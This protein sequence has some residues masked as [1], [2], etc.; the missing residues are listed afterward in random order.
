H[1]RLP[2]R[3]RYDSRLAVATSDLDTALLVSPK[4]LAGAC[5]ECL[6]SQH[7]CLGGV[8]GTGAVSLLQDPVEPAAQLLGLRP[9]QILRQIPLPAG[10][11]QKRNSLVVVAAP[12]FGRGIAPTME[13]P[14]QG[15]P[16]ET[17]FFDVDWRT[18]LHEHFGDA[19]VSTIR[20]P[21][22]A[23]LSVRPCID[24]NT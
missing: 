3:D 8:P 5:Q 10:G 20:S 6:Q 17:L 13:C 1:L 15:C 9:V 23:G 19:R 21:V 22:Q 18:S 12:G 11:D 16:P 24:G 2:G 4:Y 14:A 7:G